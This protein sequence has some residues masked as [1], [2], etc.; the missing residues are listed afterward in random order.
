LIIHDLQRLEEEG[1]P[2][3]HLAP[4]V[5]P[6]R[7]VFHGFDRSRWKAGT[8][9]ERLSVLPA[10]QEHILKLDDGKNRFVK[11]VADLSKAFALAVPHDKAIEIR[12]DVGRAEAA[13]LE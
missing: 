8:P 3:P 5:Q 10:A 7:G 4:V 1:Q 9:Q 11:A 2:G 13:G 6:R 12:D